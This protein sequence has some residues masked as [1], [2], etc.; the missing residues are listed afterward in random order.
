MRLQHAAVVVRSRLHESAFVHA[1]LRKH[2]C[3]DIQDA[4][5]EDETISKDPYA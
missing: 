4:R 2:R 3:S 5:A 1:I